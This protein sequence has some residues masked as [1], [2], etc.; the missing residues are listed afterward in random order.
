MNEHTKKP[1]SNQGAATPRSPPAEIQTVP[2]PSHPPKPPRVSYWPPMLH[3]TPI[4][5][6]RSPGASKRLRVLAAAWAAAAPLAFAC[7][8]MIRV[9][10]TT[11]SQ[12]LGKTHGALA[13]GPACEPA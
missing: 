13:M 5:L 12:I 8:W 6:S 4:A 9:H 3:S 2:R 7:A 11:P 10:Q 1:L